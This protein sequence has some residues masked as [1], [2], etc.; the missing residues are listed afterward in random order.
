MLYNYFR[1]KDVLCGVVNLRNE[2]REVFK[3]QSNWSS[4]SYYQGGA[5]KPYLVKI[6]KIIGED[7]Y[8]LII[9]EL[10]SKV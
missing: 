6:E 7:L 1:N 10:S 4:K 8:K 9:Q 5:I 3:Y 2:N